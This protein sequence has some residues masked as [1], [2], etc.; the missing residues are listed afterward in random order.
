MVD[1]V[2]GITIYIWLV[3]WNMTCY[4]P[5]HT[6]DVIRNPLTNSMIFQDG[7][8]APPTSQVLPFI[9]IDA[10]TPLQMMLSKRLVVTN[11]TSH[12]WRTSHTTF[13]A[14]GIQKSTLRPFIDCTSH[15]KQ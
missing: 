7:H 5:F 8:I 13:R 4:F 14:T 12:G 9:A 3:V 11:K 6:W 10:G 15:A 1:T 2:I